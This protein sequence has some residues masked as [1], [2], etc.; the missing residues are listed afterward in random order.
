[1]E[2][3]AARRRGRLRADHGDRARG[4]DGEA[5]Q[6]DLPGAG[7]AG[8][9]ARRPAAEPGG[10]S[11]DDGHHAAAGDE[12][13][14][15]GA[16]R[17]APAGVRGRRVVPARRLRTRA[18]R[19]RVAGEQPARRAEQDHLLPAAVPH[20]QPPRQHAPPRASYGQRRRSCADL[21]RGMYL[22]VY[23][24]IYIYVICI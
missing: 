15:R 3:P 6:E 9:A 20:H 14:A 12:R 7:G 23:M 2:R 13:A 21:R 4:A 11:G 5:E 1:M 17:D 10:A 19:W 16:K 24:Y 22:V 18:L 8:G